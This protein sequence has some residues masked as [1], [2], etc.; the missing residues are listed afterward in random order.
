MTDLSENIERLAGEQVCAQVMA[1]GDSI[2]ASKTAK[3][4]LWVKDAI[5]RLDLLV[6]EAT[7]AQIMRDCGYRCAARTRAGEKL[8]K[9]R[10][11]F[12]TLDALLDDMRSRPSTGTRVE[13]DGDIVYLYYTPQSLARPVRCYCPLLGKLPDGV[14]VSP[15]FCQCSLGFTKKAW[16]AVLGRPVQ[17]EI[18]E[19]C[20]CGAS[21]CKFAIHIGEA[22]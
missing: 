9:Q 11:R 18:L 5:D 15:T 13:R 12:P 10:R 17:V 7:R 2:A 1:G 19:S 16:E 3:C 8:R 22:V 4:A 14:T 20:A 6:D 21:E